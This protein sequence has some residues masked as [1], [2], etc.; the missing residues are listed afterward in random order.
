MWTV[1]AA[2]ADP[3]ARAAKQIICQ[4]GHIQRDSEYAFDENT[5]GQILMIMMMMMMMMM[6]VI[7]QMPNVHIHDII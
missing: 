2:R 3:V 5:E 6:M 7:C 1:D 4:P